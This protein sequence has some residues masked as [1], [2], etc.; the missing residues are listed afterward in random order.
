MSDAPAV[1]VDKASGTVVYQRSYSVTPFRWAVY[2]EQ[3]DRFC[4]VIVA[5]PSY[6]RSSR[7]LDFALNAFIDPN[8]ISADSLGDAVRQVGDLTASPEQLR[9]RAAIF[10]LSDAGQ[11][12]GLHPSLIPAPVDEKDWL[13]RHHVL[14]A[15]YPNWLLQWPDSDVWHKNY[16]HTL[17]L[18]SD[19]KE[20]PRVLLTNAH[21]LFL[22]EPGA[23]GD[24]MRDRLGAANASVSPDVILAVA[25]ILERDVQLMTLPRDH[26][27]RDPA[28]ATY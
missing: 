14:R 20:V 8:F 23:I 9:K 17:W 15:V 16:S 11:F 27:A 28:P 19:L 12:A 1:S 26:L 5:S 3:W 13:G 22:A 25:N 2:P 18:A 7:L 4:V 21:M 10:D 24:Y 6:L